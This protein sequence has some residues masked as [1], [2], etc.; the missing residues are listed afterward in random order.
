MLSILLCLAFTY[1]ALAAHQL[2]AAAFAVHLPALAVV[3]AI[4]RLSPALAAVWA[5]GI[6]LGLDAL[7][8]GL[9]GV[10]AASF[11]AIVWLLAPILRDDQR[12]TVFPVMI[13][14][15]LVVLADGA[16]SA[17]QQPPPN[18]ELWSGIGV[19]LA[20]TLF[21]TA[22]VAGLLAFLGRWVFGA[23]CTTH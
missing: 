17:V 13:A 10:H 6:G 19:H 15:L 7:G 5:F 1:F 11:V 20:T 21:V 12:R 3:L 8:G 23:P 22:A 16:A 18:R 2:G 4:R 9:L 14:V